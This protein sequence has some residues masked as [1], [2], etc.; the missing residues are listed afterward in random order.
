MNTTAIRCDGCSTSTPDPVECDHRTL[1]PDCV[2]D[3]GCRAC[4]RI[5]RDEIGATR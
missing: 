3:Q 2:A 1:C 4:Y 5:H